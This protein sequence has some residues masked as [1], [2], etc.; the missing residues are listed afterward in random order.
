MRLAHSVVPV[1]FPLDEELALLPG[2]LT[3]SLHEAVVR[4]G[5]RMTF[6]SVVQE[7]AFLKHVTTT[8]ATVRRQ[9]ETA[10]AAYVALQ[11]E[12][13]ERVERILPPVP[14]GAARQLVSVDGAMVPLVHG[15]WAEVK[16]VVLGAIQPPVLDA[17]H[18]EMVVRTTELSYFS[19]LAEAETFTRLATVETQRR[20]TERAETVCAVQDGAEWIQG[21]IDVQCQEAVRILDFSHAAGYVAQVGQAVLGEGTP[22]FQTW[23]ATTLHE[24]KHDSPDQVLQTLRNMQRELE[25]GTTSPDT[26]DTVHTAVQYLEKRR[27]QMAYADFQAAGYPIGSGSVE[28]GNKVVIEARLKGAGM[29]WARSHVNPLVAL[30]NVLCSERWEEDWSAIATRVRTDHWTVR[31]ERQRARWQQRRASVPLNSNPPSCAPALVVESRP[32]PIAVIA[33]TVRTPTSDQ[34]KL[35]YRPSMNHPWRRSP[36]GRARFKSSRKLTDPKI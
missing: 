35:S 30:R 22:E 14:E 12:A 1:F 21:F 5:T 31:Q 36:I 33:P 26:L 10:G 2:S 13:V 11:T 4:L 29:R 6:R 8:E 7:L 19:R 9:T 23:L 20:G 34:P 16:T 28:S 27:S 3:P 32:E 17:P 15:E 25:G 18:A 24:L